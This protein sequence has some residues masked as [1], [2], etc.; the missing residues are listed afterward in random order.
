M[1]TQGEGGI[2]GKRGESFD[3][4]ICRFFYFCMLG[5][6]L[7]SALLAQM[8]KKFMMQFGGDQIELIVFD[9]RNHT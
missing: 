1:Q 8:I 2:G 3:E 4:D 6:E 9:H 7:I 5:I